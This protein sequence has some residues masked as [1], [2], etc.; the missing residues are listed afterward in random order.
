MQLNLICP[1]IDLREAYYMRH[2]FTN[3]P[4]NIQ[5][6]L[7]VKA[8]KFCAYPDEEGTPAIFFTVTG[9]KEPL[10]WLFPKHRFGFE[11]ATALRDAVLEQI[12]RGDYSPDFTTTQY[13]EA[14]KTTG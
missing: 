11:K 9:A 10:I 2:D 4:I 8:D 1:P 3:D 13:L 7:S 6:I 5:N 14:L 12:E